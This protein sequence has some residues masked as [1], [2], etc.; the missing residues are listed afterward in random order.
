[1]S[2]SSKNEFSRAVKGE[3]WRRAKGI[4]ECHLVPQLMA[5]L[6]GNPCNARLG[7]VGNIFYEHIICVELDGDNTLDNAAVLTRTCW[8]LKTNTYDIPA[9]ARAARLGDADHGIFVP[10]RNPLPGGRGDPRKRTIYG[11]VVD[12][13]TGKPWGER[14]NG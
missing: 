13:R 2:R 11:K 1:M 7:P 10:P 4:C 5:I 14:T 8:R 6:H 9:I 12:R 3:A